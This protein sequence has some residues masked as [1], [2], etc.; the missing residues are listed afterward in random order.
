VVSV[1]PGSAAAMELEAPQLEA[2]RRGLRV[3]TRPAA[4][5]PV[6]IHGD[7]NGLRLAQ[8]GGGL[9]VFLSELRGKLSLDMTSGTLSQH[10]FSTVYTGARLSL[11]QVYATPQLELAGRLG[12]HDFS[13]GRDL[14]SWSG[15]ATWHVTDGTLG[16]VA[17]TREPLLPLAGPA[18]FRQFN[19]MLDMAAAGPGFFRTAL[20]GF[21]EFL[22]EPGHRARV[23]VEGAR[24]EDGNRQALAYAHYQLPLTDS[25]RQ[26]TVVRPN[27][28]FESFQSHRDSYFSPKHHLTVGTM[29]H[30]LVRYPHWDLEVEVNP[31]LLRTDGI[32]GW[33]AHGLVDA[34]FTRGRTAADVGA[35]LFYDGLQD[36]LQWRVGGRVTV[37]LGR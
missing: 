3:A 19:R 17:A 36:Y 9:D 32:N 34:R 33:G 31:Q 1:R 4:S 23:E 14:L 29:L 15:V 20:R 35:F 26:W 6:W 18:P 8:A 37:K 2:A 12:F 27:V 10:A 24:L 11:A 7:T 13:R 30:S 25:V 28:F 5:L 16:G 21:A 22:T